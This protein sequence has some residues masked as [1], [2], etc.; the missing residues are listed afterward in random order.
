MQKESSET[1]PATIRKVMIGGLRFPTVL[2]L[3]STVNL[4]CVVSKLEAV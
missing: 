2:F 3:G 1:D 4:L